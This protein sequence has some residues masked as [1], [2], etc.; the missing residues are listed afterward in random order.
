LLRF[1]ARHPITFFVPYRIVAGLA[2]VVL[3]T[4]GVLTAT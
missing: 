1:V 3:L 4:T 2:I